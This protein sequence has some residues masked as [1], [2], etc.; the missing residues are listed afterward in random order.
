MQMGGEE[1]GGGL[2]GWSVSVL[3]KMRE[4]GAGDG[5]EVVGWPL[6]LGHLGESGRVVSV[7]RVEG[8]V[9]AG[10]WRERRTGAGA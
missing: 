7:L 4:E 1:K 6:A 9:G 5:A 8:A 10:A 2:A 3:V